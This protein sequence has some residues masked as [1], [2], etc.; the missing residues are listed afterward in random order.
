TPTLDERTQAA[1]G[2]LTF[3]EF[4]GASPPGATQFGAAPTPPADATLEVDVDAGRTATLADAAAVVG[5][6]DGAY[7]NDSTPLATPVTVLFDNV[8]SADQASWNALV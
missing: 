4:N 5:S 2:A 7:D 8:P 3:S 1:L 6:A